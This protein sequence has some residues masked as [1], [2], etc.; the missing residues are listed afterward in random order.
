MIGFVILS[1]IIYFLDH[2]HCSRAVLITY[3]ATIWV[4]RLHHNRS[5]YC[6]AGQC[7]RTVIARQE[8]LRM[9]EKDLVY[10]FNV[11]TTFTTSDH[12]DSTTY[13]ALSPRK[14]TY[15]KELRRKEKEAAVGFEPTN[16]GF[17]IRRLGPLGYAARFRSCK[18]SA[19]LDAKIP[20]NNPGIF[21]RLPQNRPRPNR[22][23]AFFPLPVFLHSAN[24]DVLSGS[25]RG[26]WSLSL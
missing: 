19:S 25:R 8:P 17:A 22:L 14:L 7:Q 10:R 23:P 3:V 16:N 13:E 4:F 9:H 26:L 21:T 15:C 20:F 11:L 6:P 18:R 2:E 24:R 1:A 5:V 12:P